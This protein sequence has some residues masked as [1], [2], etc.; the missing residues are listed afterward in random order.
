[1]ALSAAEVAAIRQGSLVVVVTSITTGHSHVLLI[2]DPNP[3]AISGQT[4]G[5][6]KRLY[7]QGGLGAPNKPLQL[8]G[9]ARDGR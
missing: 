5:H 7:D 1:V 2:Q 9:A 6:V 4:W 3:V 8:P